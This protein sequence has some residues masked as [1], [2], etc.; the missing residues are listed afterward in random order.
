MPDIDYVIGIIMQSK[1]SP[2][3]NGYDDDDDAPVGA[4]RGRGAGD[5]GAM[6][7]ASD[8]FHLRQQRVKTEGR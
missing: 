2:E 3:S 6:P 7:V 4:K 1:L 8:I 5:G